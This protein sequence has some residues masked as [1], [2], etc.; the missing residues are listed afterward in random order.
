MTCNEP[1]HVGLRP[2]QELYRHSADE[3]E[4]QTGP[5]N[6]QV[7]LRVIA[8]VNQRMGLNRSA[9]QLGW[10]AERLLANRAENQLGP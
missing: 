5:I 9:A 4:R 1:S 3:L 2:M 8:G 7:A 6:Y 10:T